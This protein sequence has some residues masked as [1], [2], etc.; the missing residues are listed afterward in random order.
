MTTWIQLW[1]LMLMPTVILSALAALPT[2]P[3]NGRILGGGPVRE[4]YLNHLVL[5]LLPADVSLS[6]VQWFAAASALQEWIFA[7]AVAINVNAL[8]LPLLYV[9][10]IGVIRA[11]S[12]FAKKNIQLK[13]DALR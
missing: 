12:W 4:V 9:F 3:F 10:G 5:P 6:L 1:P 13:R 2:L 7:L 11:S 8:M